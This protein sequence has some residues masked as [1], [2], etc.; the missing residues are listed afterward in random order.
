MKLPA[1]VTVAVLGPTAAIV[2]AEPADLGGPRQWAVLARL[3]VAGGDLERHLHHHPGREEAVRLL[4]LALYRSGRQGDALGV[5]RRARTHLAEE[6]GVDPGPALRSLEAD[7]LA[8]APHLDLPLAAGDLMPAADG[9]V[10]AG[11]DR[12]SGGRA[13]RAPGGRAGRAPAIGRGAELAAIS[14][15]AAEAEREGARIVWVGGEA[16]VGKTTIAESAAAE[17]GERG[18]RVARGRCP[19]VEGAPPGWPWSEVLDSLDMPASVRRRT[20]RTLEAR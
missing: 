2:D 4:A 10:R 3:V 9:S 15:A 8:Q 11:H 6:L 13:G 20:F 18:W 16:G 7:V 19:E 12:A 5:L 14:A 17:L 1:P